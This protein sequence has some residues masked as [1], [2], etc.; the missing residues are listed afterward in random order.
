MPPFSLF[1]VPIWVALGSSEWVLG[2]PI[3]SGL[4]SGSG[5]DRCFERET[6]SGIRIGERR[7]VAKL[8]SGLRMGFGSGVMGRIMISFMVRVRVTIRAE[9]SVVAD[10]V[11]P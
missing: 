9:E 6:F 4:G 10:E 5:L 2:L 11:L 3:G 1:G 7:I 8:G